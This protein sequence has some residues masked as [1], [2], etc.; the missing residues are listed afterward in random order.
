M[1]RF[2]P[3][4]LLP[5]AACLKFAKEEKV[6]F[7]LDTIQ[8]S[9]LVISRSVVAYGSLSPLTQVEIKSEASGLVATMDVEVGDRVEAGQ[10][11]VSLDREILESRFRQQEAVLLQTEAS[12]GTAQIEL[13]AS[14]RDL[15]KLQRLVD[16][17]Y[18]T[19]DELARAQ[20]RLERA[21]LSV[22]SAQASKDQSAESVSSAQDDLDNATIPSPRN[23]V[24]LAVYVEEGS[25]VASATSGLGNGTPIALVGDMT[26]MKFLG[27]VDETEI[28][29]LQDE[30]EANVNVQSYPEDSF[31]GTLQRIYPMG[32]NQGG[33]VSY[34][35]EIRI[36]NPDRTLLPGMTAEARFITS[37]EEM[38]GLPDSALVFEEDKAFVWVMRAPEDDPE[39]EPVPKKV[40]VEIG[41]I[42]DE[43]VEILS[44]VEA[45][46]FV[47]DRPGTEM[48]ALSPVKVRMSRRRH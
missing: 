24:I 35:V 40:K 48:D 13:E 20:D 44:G 4:L 45:G 9:S 5:F 7:D 16:E 14:E 47:V 23:G 18:G 31:P 3:L 30:M 27:L 41:F 36:P 8:V 33:V 25:A 34:Q 22:A 6:E 38:M 15:T 17:G 42:G 12:L 26:V 46:E 32:Q 37:S 29:K 19:V 10:I 1:N 2:L 21:H 28:G 39:G 43:A 11:I